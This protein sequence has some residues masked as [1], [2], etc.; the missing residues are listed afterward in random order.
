MHRKLALIGVVTL[1]GTLALATPALA[2]NHCVITLS[3]TTITEGGSITV[4]GTGFPEGHVL[5]TVTGDVPFT[6]PAPAGPDGTISF[7]VGPIP[8]AGTYTI[9]A[10]GH[11]S[12]PPCNAPSQTVTVTAA[13]APTPAPTPVPPG[14]TPA[15]A[16]PAPTPAGTGTLPDAALSAPGPAIDAAALGLVLLSSAAVLY[17]V[18]W[19]RQRAAR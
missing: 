1:L 15:P 18:Q 8:A 10:V 9:N 11:G 12:N 16:T 2:T 4:T 3:S 17:A 14:A 6:P 13:A 19:R 5:V 7:S